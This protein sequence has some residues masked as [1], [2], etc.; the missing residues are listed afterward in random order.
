MDA[1]DIL[2]DLTSHPRAAA[3]ALRGQ[4]NPVSLNARPGGHDNSVAW[5]LW[6][7]GREIDVQLADLTGDEQLWTARGFDARF[8][9]GEVGDSVGYGHSSAEARRILIEDGE[10]LLEYVAAALAALEQHLEMITAADLE[11]VIDA[12]W[13]PPVTRGARLVSIV[14]DAVQHIAQAAYV[15]GMPLRD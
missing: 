1:L 15:L 5:L 3:E 11:D 10:G 6:H 8:A 12:Q 14:D 13:D 2:R 9:L 4:L 7:T